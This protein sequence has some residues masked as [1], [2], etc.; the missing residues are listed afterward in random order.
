LI[1]N[2]QHYFMSN[3]IL[4]YIGEFGFTI[5]VQL[6][7]HTKNRS[8][9]PVKLPFLKHPLYFR[10]NTADRIIFEQ[11]FVEKQ[12]DFDIQFEPKVIIDL[13]TNVGFASVLFANRFASATI[14]AVEPEED[15]FLAAKKNTSPYKNITLIEGAVWHRSELINLVDKGHGEAAY[16]IESGDGNHTVQA[17]TIKEIM[18]LM[19]IKIIDILKIDIEGAEKEIFENGYE[20]WVP[21]TKVIVVETHDRYKK[22]TSKAVFNT[23]GKYNFSLE[24]SGENLVLYNNDLI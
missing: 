21:F 23:I 11:I 22:G 1:Q 10:T 19:N 16:M 20:D 4:K 3:R 9:V 7:F 12:Y 24:L 8:A 17:Y 6:Y 15:N 2:S 5:G 18:T 13:G 14:F